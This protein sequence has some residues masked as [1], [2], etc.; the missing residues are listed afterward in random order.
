MG[1]KTEEKY[2]AARELL[3][4]SGNDKELTKKAVE[5]LEEAVKCGHVKS[6]FLLGKTYLENKDFYDPEKAADLFLLAAQLEDSRSQ[7]FYGKMAFEGQGI[8]KNLEKASIWLTKASNNGVELADLFLHKIA[9][10]QPELVEKYNASDEVSKHST[11]SQPSDTTESF[12][13]KLFNIILW[14]LLAGILYVSIENKPMKFIYIALPFPIMLSLL[15]GW[16]KGFLSYCKYFFNILLTYFFIFSIFK[17]GLIQINPYL[18]IFFSLI[19]IPFSLNYISN[20]IPFPKRST[21]LIDSIFGSLCKLA[22]TLVIA[23]IATIFIPYF[24]NNHHLLNQ[25]SI[26]IGKA[27]EKNSVA[28]CKKFLI[29]PEHHHLI[30]GPKDYEGLMVATAIQEGFIKKVSRPAEIT[31]EVKSIDEVENLTFPFRGK[32][33]KIA[34][35]EIARQLK[36]MVKQAL[37]KK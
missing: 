20:W 9:K 4:E 35:K 30:V 34:N 21:G 31:L 32:Y 19:I 11:K 26:R 1:I 7:F 6:M 16:Y 33:Y 2:T 37:E 27:L 29:T 15:L 10:T 12:G 5:I 22:I 36:M 13:Y 28:L 14:G 25:S 23:S 24:R 8:E 17:I 3:F 18:A